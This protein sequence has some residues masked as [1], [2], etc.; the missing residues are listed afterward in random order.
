MLVE[1]L[2]LDLPLAGFNGGLFV[3]PDLSIIDDRRLPRDVAENSIDILTK[4]GLD[5]WVYVGNDWL[6]R[7]PKAPHVEREAWTVK[8]RPVVVGS[9]HDMLEKGHQDRR[10]QRSKTGGAS[11]GIDAG[12]FGRSGY[13][14]ALSALLSRHHP[15]RR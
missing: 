1:P 9:F 14:S 2:A 8:F 12:G 4:S 15:S 5:I 3:N 6:I 11:R 7:N 13:R 10:R